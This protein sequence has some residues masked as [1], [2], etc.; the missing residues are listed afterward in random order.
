MPG[1][2]RQPYTHG[3]QARQI[4]NDAEDDLR[5]WQPEPEDQHLGSHQH[6]TAHD[7]KQSVELSSPTTVSSGGE[8]S[9]REATHGGIAQNVSGNTGGEVAN[10]ASTAQ[11]QG[12]PASAKRGAAGGGGSRGGGGQLN[13]G[14]YGHRRRASDAE[15]EPQSPQQQLEGSTIVTAGSP[16]SSVGGW[17]HHDGGLPRHK[18]SG[19]AF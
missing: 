8:L 15:I 11:P 12:E 16:V 2:E 6:E 19:L 1:D 9:P 7:H 10:T 5:D 18:Q 17:R 3:A 4:L 14:V 13:G